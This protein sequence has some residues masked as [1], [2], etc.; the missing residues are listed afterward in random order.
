MCLKNSYISE[1][2][3]LSKNQAKF[4]LIIASICILAGLWHLLWEW[5]EPSWWMEAY[6]LEIIAFY[7]PL[8]TIFTITILD[9][10]IPKFLGNSYLKTI[11]ASFLLDSLI[12]AIFCLVPGDIRWNLEIF[13]IFLNN[14]SGLFLVCHFIPLVI[15]LFGVRFIFNRL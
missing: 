14:H 6:I 3:L 8:I 11:L 7:P 13:P 15:I 9:I 10:F 4:L 5:L 12:S 2:I 1:S